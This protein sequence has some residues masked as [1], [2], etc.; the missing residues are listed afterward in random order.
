MIHSR[1]L[2][3]E[4]LRI[5]KPFWLRVSLSTGMGIISGLTLTAM[6][7]TINAAIAN[8]NGP[9]SLL[10]LQFAGL[11]LVTLAL[12]TLSSI[13]S[14]YVGQ[15]VIARMQRELTAKILTAP[16]DQIERFHNHRLLP[17]L[18]QD[19]ATV[20]GFA[21][22]VAPLV[23]ALAV[24]FACLGYLAILSWQLLLL[25]LVIIALGSLAQY[26]AHKH[27]SKNL[28]AAR[29]ASDEMHKHFHAI[30]NGC[31]ELRIQRERRYQ[32]QT[33]HIQQTTER[34]AAEN[35]H[36]AKIFVSAE[37]F[38]SMLFFMVIGMTIGIKA[39]IPSMDNSILGGVVLIM[40]YMKGPLYQLINIMPAV[41]QAQ[42]AFKR[43][44]D[45]SEKFDNFEP[46]LL[47]P[48]ETNQKD[49]SFRKIEIRNVSY[50]FLPKLKLEYNN[51]H[52]LEEV[53]DSDSPSFR[54][55]PVSLDITPGDILFIVGDNGCGK[56]TL[57]KILLGLYAPSE[58]SIAW[59]N[60]LITE[61][62]RD[63]YRQLF[64]T[65]FSDYFLFE[66][67]NKAKNYSHHKALELLYRLE[68]S[69]KVSLQQGVFSTTDLSTGQRKRLAL[70]NAWLDKRPILVFDEWAADQS[71][72]FKRIF[73]TEILPELK[74]KGK[75]IV[76]ISHD[77]YYFSTAEKVIHMKAG[78]IIA[79]S[80]EI[81]E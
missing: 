15:H 55:G 65:V 71:P 27:G 63:F 68:I 8:P 4:I 35:I 3:R 11:C 57:L 34:I 60:Q 13:I 30:A 37:T 78:K 48:I 50:Q 21:L 36:A 66:D 14:S 51:K 79:S 61:Q 32:I 5:L 22:S 20:S 25:I 44:T 6:L 2:S 53:I 69:H 38:G 24:T 40:L 49:L 74:A 28:Q 52:E 81:N 39:L 67:L 77:D 47:S 12:Q 62:N 7:A 58:G 17:I 59:D 33:E 43:L 31:K 45:L 46:K 41:T 9:N 10:A 54:V 70:L 64:T 19:I 73:Y 80:L 29:E 26:V 18:V 1:S 72:E 75:T 56:T 16:I 76:I 23:I 42:I